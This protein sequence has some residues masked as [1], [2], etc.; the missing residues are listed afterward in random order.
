MNG[1]VCL[2]LYLP[3]Q[4]NI[5]PRALAFFQQVKVV[6]INKKGNF[7]FKC[8]LCL[9]FFCFCY[10]VWFD[11]QSRILLCPWRFVGLACRK[12]HQM[13]LLVWLLP[14]A[15]LVLAVGDV[16]SFCAQCQRSSACNRGKWGRLSLLCAVSPAVHHLHN[17]NGS[18][19]WRW[20]SRPVKHG[21]FF[22][23]EG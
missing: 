4:I 8:M 9:V 11:C 2:W 7:V 1:Y 12:H 3:F 23:L 14:V 19:C 20:Q 17:S 18:L 16:N 15:S 21:V 10:F 22:S 13:S 5:C 6:K